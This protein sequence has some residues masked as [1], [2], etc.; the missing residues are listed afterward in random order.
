LKLEDLDVKAENDSDF[1]T[2]IQLSFICIM[3]A[4][5][6]FNST[7]TRAQQYQSLSLRPAENKHHQS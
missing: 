3:I 4:T 5:T 1:F 2:L 7:N 6:K